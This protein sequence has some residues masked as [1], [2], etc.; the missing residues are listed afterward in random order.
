MKKIPLHQAEQPSL[1][2]QC[3][4]IVDSSPKNSWQRS[5]PRLLAWGEFTLRMQMSA[6]CLWGVCVSWAPSLVVRIFQPK[7]QTNSLL[8]TLWLPPPPCTIILIA[9]DTQSLFWAV[10]LVHNVESVLAAYCTWVKVYILALKCSACWQSEIRREAYGH[11]S[12]NGY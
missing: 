11:I 8:I 4:K 10:G 7:L 9:S 1:H 3:R 6:V 5:M 12:A 2:G